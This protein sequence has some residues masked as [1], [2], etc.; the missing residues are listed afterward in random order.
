MWNNQTSSPFSQKP[1][2]KPA[3]APQNFVEALK[4]IG[5]YTAS[6]VKNDLLSSGFHDVAD[7]FSGQPMGASPAEGLSNPDRSENEWL[8]QKEIEAE[9]ARR[10]RHREIAEVTPIYDRQAEAVKAQVEALRQDLQALANEL[11]SMAQ[12]TQNAIEAE[13]AHPGTYHVSFF[14]KLRHFIIL[15]RKQVSES[16]N[17]LELSYN[18][19][20][21]QNLFWGNFNKSGTKY[22][23]SAEH[24]MSTSAG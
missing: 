16:Q 8:R 20:Q 18:R 2:T 21:A 24:Y 5:G 13:I 3:R 12:S 11:G 23:L 10:E 22:L 1:K 6:S 4:G 19:R 17:W 14:E 9:T 7:A 15:L